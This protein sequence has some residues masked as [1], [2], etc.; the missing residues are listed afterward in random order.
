MSLM[1]WVVSRT[2]YQP[3]RMMNEDL[4]KLD[5]HGLGNFMKGISTTLNEDLKEP[6]THLTCK[7]VWKKLGNVL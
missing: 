1:A 4:K 7:C 3:L 5:P 2:V 6:D